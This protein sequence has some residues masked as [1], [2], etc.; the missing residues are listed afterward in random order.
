MGKFTKL[1]CVFVLSL[2][3]G[4]SYGQASSDSAKS[5][6][7]QHRIERDSTKDRQNQRQFLKPDMDSKNYNFYQRKQISQPL[8]PRYD[9]DSAVYQNGKKKRKQQAAY[10][11]RQYAFPAK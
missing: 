3:A 1:L 8:M 2:S 5:E 7:R 9:L 4:F 10:L 6:R 11:G